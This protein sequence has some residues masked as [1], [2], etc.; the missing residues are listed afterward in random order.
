MKKSITIVYLL[1]LVTTLSAFDLRVNG[2]I[3]ATAGKNDNTETSVANYSNKIKFQ[4]DSLVG[5]QIDS[6]VSDDFSAT[7]QL[8]GRFADEEAKLNV[9]WAYITYEFN[10]NIQVQIG[11]YRQAI[12]M[13]SNTIDIAYSYLWSRVPIEVYNSAPI[14]YLDGVNFI[15]NYEFDNELQFDAKLYYGT[16]NNKNTTVGVNYHLIVDSAIGGE[17]ILSNDYFKLRAG[18]FTTL[19]SMDIDGVPNI[20]GLKI[21]NIRA[22]FYSL[23]TTVN[24]NNV[25]VIGELFHRTTD[26][27]SILAKDLDG[28]YI[29]LAY[30]INNF[31]P[32]ITYSSLDA[33][34]FDS[35]NPLISGARDVF[36]RDQQSI[37]T[38][39]RYEINPSTAL[40]VEWM[41]TDQKQLEGQVNDTVSNLYT[42]A[43][44][45]VF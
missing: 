37:T 17:L 10:D 22:N 33:K 18:Y 29:T 6:S 8:V 7:V 4:P 42:V 20:D 14:K 11:R 21:D 36:A 26:D 25:Q 38:G 35:N 5:V 23:G 39:L 12:Y 43:L 30:T 40:K 32:N 41:R 24:Y 19:F 16:L 31:T 34:L 3:N 28:Y 9:E 15:Y 1:L 13:Y 2:F 44:N 27:E 45:L